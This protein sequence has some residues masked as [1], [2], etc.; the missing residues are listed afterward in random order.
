MQDLFFSSIVALVYFCLA[1]SMA[2]FSVEWRNL[3]SLS[4]GSGGSWVSWGSGGSGDIPEDVSTIADS[5]AA[6]AVSCTLQL[7]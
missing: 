2:V 7:Y 5:L 3:E 1:I 6:A 4:G